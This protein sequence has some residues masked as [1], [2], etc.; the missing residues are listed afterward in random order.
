MYP[1]P[2]MV[3]S[4]VRLSRLEWPTVSTLLRLVV[5]PCTHL[6]RSRALYGTARVAVTSTAARCADNAFPVRLLVMP[7]LPVSSWRVSSPSTRTWR[8]ESHRPTSSYRAPCSAPTPVPGQWPVLKG[9]LPPSGRPLS[10]LQLSATLSAP[11]P[12]LR[13]R[14]P[15]I[16]A[17]QFQP[18]FGTQSGPVADR[19]NL[20]NLYP[21]IPGGLQLRSSG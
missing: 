7:L 12:N 11:P 20:T 14:C 16:R 21:L 4:R 10:D 6:Q 15:A 1:T 17:A 3:S 18:V 19:I 2:L 5:M 9:P 13:R 8:A